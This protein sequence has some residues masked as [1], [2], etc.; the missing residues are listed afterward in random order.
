M[1]AKKVTP[2]K[3]EGASVVTAETVKDLIGKANVYIFDLRKAINYG[4][5]HIKGA[6]SNPFK[7]VKKDKDPAKRTGTFDTSK[8]PK[9]K[10]ATLVFHSDG[11]TGWKSY[12]GSKWAVDNGYKNV[13]YLREGSAGWFDK[14]YPTD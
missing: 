2:T 9:D 1:A 10:N 4:K 3:L 13:M 14:G 5:G 7:W 12:Y 6:I 8:L 11:P